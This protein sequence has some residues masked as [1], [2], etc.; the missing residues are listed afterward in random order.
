MN[1]SKL[2]QIISSS[3]FKSADLG[4]EDNILDSR[5]EAPF[6]SEWVEIYTLIS[7]EYEQTKPQEDEEAIESIRKSAFFASEQFF[8]THEISSYISDDFDLIAKAIVTN[9][10]DKRITWLLDYYINHGI[11]HKLIK[12]HE[13]SILD[14]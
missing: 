10:Q 1:L 5:D 6:D 14:Y 3:I 7:Q 9:T 12:T 4:N 8:G 13:K 2:H 11:P